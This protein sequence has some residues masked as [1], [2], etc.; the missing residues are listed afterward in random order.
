MISGQ[1]IMNRFRFLLPALSLIAGLIGALVIA[2][3]TVTEPGKP[4]AARALYDSPSP[5]ASGILKVVS[6]VYLAVWILCGLAALLI[7]FHKP[8]AV[9]ALTNL[10]ESWFGLAIAA[11]YSYFGIKK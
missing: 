1:R 5:R 8:D 9:E 3:L 11:A 6:T 10:G 4:L 2:E 7:S